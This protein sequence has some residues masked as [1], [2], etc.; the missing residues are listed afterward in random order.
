MNENIDT[1]G[2]MNVHPSAIL[3]NLSRRGSAVVLASVPR[4]VPVD[5]HLVTIVQCGIWLLQFSDTA[6]DRRLIPRT[7]QRFAS[8][9][10]NG[11]AVR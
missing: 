6:V 8:S 7:G 2:R 5:P 11:A 10:S 3:N 9:F 4:R 1:Y